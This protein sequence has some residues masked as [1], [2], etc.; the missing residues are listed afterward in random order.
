MLDLLLL[1][2]ALL[3]V[4]GLW[5]VR[6]GD[7]RRHGHLMAAAVTL[8]AVR[9]ALASSGL[10]RALR[11]PA[12]LVFAL[13]AGTIF[14]GRRALAWREGRSLRPDAPRLHRAAGT[15]TLAVLA[16]ATVAWLLRR[17]G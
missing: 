11:L 12:G 7:P 5:A 13:A 6:R 14:L 17:W 4:L 3:L 9:M 1:P 2:A 8:A 16:L 10:P 15:L